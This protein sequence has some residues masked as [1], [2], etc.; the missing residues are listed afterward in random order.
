MMKQHRA[1]SH[2]ETYTGLYHNMKLYC[3]VPHCESTGVYSDVAPAQG[4]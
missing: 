4:D 3:T 2:D 1:I